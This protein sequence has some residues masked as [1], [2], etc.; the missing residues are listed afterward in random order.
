MPRA[1][2]SLSNTQFHKIY[3]I[4]YKTFGPQHWWPGESPFEIMVGAILTQNTNWHNASRAIKNIKMAGLL[5]PK[6]MLKEHRRIPRLIKTAGFYRMK[7][8]YLHEFLEYYVANYGGKVE[9]ISKRETHVIR[10]E[11]LSVH[12]IGPETADAVLLYAL[13]KRSFVV[14]AYTRRIFSRHGMVEP[15]ASYRTLQETIVNNL[16]KSTRIYNEFHALLVRVGK[17][18]CRRNE[19]LCTA[20]PL[21]TLPQSA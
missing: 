14:D 18:Y 1:N 10:R 2:T 17:E 6:R 13:G 15:D 12:G 16:P 20:C 5:D 19:P 11:L 8:R 9:K 3:K 4:L 7:S 21:G